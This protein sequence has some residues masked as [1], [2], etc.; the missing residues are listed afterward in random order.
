VVRQRLAVLYIRERVVH[1]FGTRLA[2][3]ARLGRNP[4]SRG[5]VGK[6]AGAELARFS[7]SVAAELL[8]C[9]A[10][11]WAGTDRKAA[12]G[13]A[14][15]LS[16]PAGGIAGAATRSSATSS[17]SGCSACRKNR[18]S[19]ATCR[20]GSSASAPGLLRRV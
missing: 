19:T 17:G 2:Q 14:A 11:A 1:L 4:G 10:I 18:R 8:G 5:S 3:E 16:A 9:D 20:S 7:A 15:L 12:R 6:L 13:A